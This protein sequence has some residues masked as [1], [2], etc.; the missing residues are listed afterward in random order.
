MLCDADFE[1]VSRVMLELR[2]ELEVNISVIWIACSFVLGSEEGERIFQWSVQIIDN[3]I[4]FI[5]QNN[6]L[7]IC[8]DRII[9]YGGFG[10]VYSA[11]FKSIQCSV[12]VFDVP[13]P[14]A[15]E[16]VEKSTVSTLMEIVGPF[17]ILSHPNLMKYLEV[18]SD[19][20]SHYPAIALEF[21]K[22]AL[23][24]FLGNLQ[25]PLPLHVQL[26]F[27]HSVALALSYLHEKGIIHGNLS[28][29]SV[30]LTEKGQVKVSD[31]EVLGVY[32]F[33]AVEH[34]ESHS[35]PYVPPE[36]FSTPTV[37]SDIFSWSV[38][39]LQIITRLFPNPDPRLKEVTDPHSLSARPI[40]VS[41][42]EISRRKSHIDLVDDSNPLLSVLVLG[43]DDVLEKRPTTAEVIDM[44]SLVKLSEEHQES[45]SKAGID[46]IERHMFVFDYELVKILEKPQPNA[47]ARS[48]M[49]RFP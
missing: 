32:P 42:S 46:W 38:L 22:G 39:V 4:L 6:S 5:S 29:Q 16:K 45:Q 15:G 37:R 36:A 21:V 19:P 28:S 23:S 7:Q 2:R 14:S 24:N 48:H 8:G 9:G 35:L 31:Y 10:T 13:R 27:S 1:S 18:T 44:V 3:L 33:I 30:Y 47:T 17:C 11:V 43:L 26:D 41:V 12:K 49:V 25:N 20:T 34:M 40:Q